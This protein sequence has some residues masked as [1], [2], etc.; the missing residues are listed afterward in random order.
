[1]KIIL[2]STSPNLD[3]EV[4]PRFG[5]GEFFLIVDPDTME[6]QP[7]PNPGVGASGGAGTLAAQFVANQNAEAVISGDFG[8]NAYDAL[9][10]A[11]VT[12]YL[13]GASTT[14]G[15][16]IKRFKAG[17]LEHVVAPTAQGHHRRG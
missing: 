10:A 8:P 4:D 1:M 11:G 13:Y 15:E 2:T 6:W 14:V 16:A 5:R 17:K 3:S 12:M 7:Y 9:Q